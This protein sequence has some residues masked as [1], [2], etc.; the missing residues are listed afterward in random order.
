MSPESDTKPGPAYGAVVVLT[1]VSSLENLDPAWGMGGN[2]MILKPEEP[3]ELKELVQSLC[4]V[5][6]RFS[7]AP[8]PLVAAQF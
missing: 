1:R 8:R 2:A 6:L 4:E 5:W 3:G 7:V